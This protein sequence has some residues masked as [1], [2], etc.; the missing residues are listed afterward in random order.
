[1][2]S[3]EF[4]EYLV[5]TVSVIHALVHEVQKVFVLNR[6]R[7]SLLVV[8]LLVDVMLIVVRSLRHPHS[9]LHPRRQGADQL[10]FDCETYERGQ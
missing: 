4:I 3:L 7:H 1:M 6:S 2:S 10:D 9:H 8:E 5:N